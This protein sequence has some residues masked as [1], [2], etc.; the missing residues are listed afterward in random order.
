[1]HVSTTPRGGT[2]QLQPIK[3]A[4]RAPMRSVLIIPF[5]GTKSRPRCLQ[6]DN[7]T[8]KINENDER[9][10]WGHKC[11]R[12]LLGAWLFSGAFG[13]C[14]GCHA[15]VRFAPH[16]RAA[17]EC[18]LRAGVLIG[19]TAPGLNVRFVSPERHSLDTATPQAR[20]QNT[21]KRPGANAGPFPN[22]T[23][24]TRRVDYSITCTMR[25]EC[26]STSTVRSLTTVYR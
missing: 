20:V 3:I 10:V 7:W 23:H 8:A 18:L 25:W 26:G 19:G 6:R 5:R 17:L 22:R 21:M 12:K 1:M 4:H 24:Q 14:D 9:F 16:Q 11:H 15:D 13:R 2:G